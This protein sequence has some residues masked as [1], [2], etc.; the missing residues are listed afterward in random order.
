VIW[1]LTKSQALDRKVFVR[2]LSGLEL[3]D[4]LRA[5]LR[6]VSNPTGQ[7]LP[8]DL[9]MNVRNPGEELRPISTPSLSQATQAELFFAHPLTSG[10]GRSWLAKANP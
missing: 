8:V 7:L 5:I 9:A 3:L 4:A 1:A 6:P 2:R 10:Q